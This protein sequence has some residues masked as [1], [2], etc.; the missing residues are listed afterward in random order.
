MMRLVPPV[1]DAYPPGRACRR[2]SCAGQAVEP[3]G[4]CERCDQLHEREL[5]R[6][7]EEQARVL[8]E[9]DRRFPGL[10]AALTV[11]HVTALPV[12]L[13]AHYTPGDDWKFVLKALRDSWME[14][15]ERLAQRM[16]EIEQAGG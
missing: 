16:I 9:I 3:Y 11:E 1:E 8:R 10:L 13:A 5:E 12:H 6:L 7:R 2:A 15:K 4:L 14:T